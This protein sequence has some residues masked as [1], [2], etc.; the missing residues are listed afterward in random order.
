[1]KLF[2]ATIAVAVGLLVGWQGAQAQSLEPQPVIGTVKAGTAALTVTAAYTASF[3]TTNIVLTEGAG[4]Q[5]ALMGLD[6][7]I[8]SN[9]WMGV[10]KAKKGDVYRFTCSLDQFKVQIG[11]CKYVWPRPINAVLVESSAKKK[12]VEVTFTEDWERAEGEE[13]VKVWCHVYA[14]NDLPTTMVTVGLTS[15]VNGEAI[16]NNLPIWRF[17]NLVFLSLVVAMGDAVKP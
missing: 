17:Y 5:A 1:M 3:G 12:V 15:G 4:A 6:A 16:T 2:I 13:A 14:D 7:S 9:C 8:L 10:D 11:D